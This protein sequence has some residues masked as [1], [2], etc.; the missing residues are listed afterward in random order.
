MPAFATLAVVAPDLVGVLLG[1]K[2]LPAGPLLR[3][4]ALG[5]MLR[6]VEASQNWLHLPLG[7]PDRMLRW[8][9]LTGL[10]QI[11]CVFVGLPFGTLGVASAIVVGRGL[12]A[13]PAVLYAGRPIQVRLR[14]VAAATIRQLAGALVVFGAGVF[15]LSVLSASQGPVVRTVVVGMVCLLSY[16]LVVPGLLS[17]T[18]PL[19]QVTKLA[20][21]LQAQKSFT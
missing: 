11:L 10:T 18:A 12:L 19:R 17:L 5:G 3:V 8:A 9:L 16:L 13:V 21:R 7:R 4:F 1:E 6:I 15:V 2:W 14:D 20:K